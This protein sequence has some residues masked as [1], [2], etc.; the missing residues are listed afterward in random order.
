MKR[1]E[2]QTSLTSFLTKKSR[3]FL[4]A[5]VSSHALDTNQLNACISSAGDCDGDVGD[6]TDFS[7]LLKEDAIDDVSIENVVSSSKDSIVRYKDISEIIG[8][9]ISDSE[10][11]H[12]L[13]HEWVPHNEF[14]FPVHDD[15]WHHSFQKSWLE[16]FKWLIYSRKEDGAYCKYCTLFTSENEGK[17]S[18]QQLG[19]FV[20]KGFRKWKKAKESFRHHAT[21]KYHL[22]CQEMAHNFL[23]VYD[24]K[25]KDIQQQ[26]SSDFTK[27]REENQAKLLSIVKTIILCGRQELP[28]RG[29]S[30][31]GNVLE[32]KEC[33]DG[34]FRALL[35]FR[36]DAGDKN[37]ES[38][39]RTGQRNA[40]YTSATIQNEII[41]ICGDVIK[42]TIVDRV[43]RS[44]AFSVLCD[45]TTDNSRTE[46][47]SLCVRYIDPDE[48]ILREDFIEFVPVQVQDLTGEGI[49]STIMSRLEAI[50]ININTLI[51]QGYDG[52]S[53]MSGSFNGA[54]AVIRRQFPLALYVHCSAHSLNLAIAD[55]CKVRALSNCL[56]TINSIGN[57]FRTS[58]LRTDV[59]KETIKTNMPESRHK[60]L[61]AMCETRWV[62]KHDSV[63]RFDELLIPI[64]EAL[65]KLKETGNRETSQAANQLISAIRS[66]NF[67]ITLKI[68]LKIFMITVNLCKFLQGVDCDLSI[69][70]EHVDDV[71]STLSEIRQNADEHYSE[72]YKHAFDAAK[73][74][75]G[76]DYEISVPRRV[77]RQIHR[78]NVEAD[79]SEEYFR[80]A[81][82]LPIIDHAI[83]HLTERFTNHKSVISSLAKLVPK[84]CVDYE[85]KDFAEVLTFYE[86]VF[87]EDNSSFPGEYAVWKSKWL[88]IEQRPSR[89]SKAVTKYCFLQ[90]ISCSGYC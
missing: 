27:K 28:L 74:L 57:F 32:E 17:G 71:I 4:P 13:R 66:D 78:N 56:G 65:E 49:A 80:R 47:M 76:D 84:R 38:H 53:A 15:K 24:G 81:L 8:K 87:P 43:N 55:T 61:I 20:N 54:Q 90:S 68:A 35:R 1:K 82:F 10:R 26:I 83:N 50:G 69:A 70:C 14:K 25:R 7:D 60:N 12:V 48:I 77:G 5:P 85:A 86:T 52:A 34:T 6:G 31:S 72:L 30:D 51:G 37:L 42:D 3:V 88:R 29:T 21:L 58:A 40:Q 75:N 9:N 46:Q 67:L 36:V 62:Q 19:Y 2:K 41:H 89:P 73:Q 64:A 63:I 23:S 39:F 33:N 45:E 18:H 22:K 59:L 16:Q 11:E 44:L 79:T